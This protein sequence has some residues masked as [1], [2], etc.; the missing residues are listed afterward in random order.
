MKK[1]LIV[2]GGLLLKGGTENFI[3][4][5]LRSL[6]RKDYQVDVVVHGF[7]KGY[8]DDEI[9]SLGMQ[10]IHVPI[11]GQNPIKN[12]QALTEI[13]K[14]GNYDVIHAHLNDQNGPVLKMAKKYNIPV[15]ISHSH[16]SQ[17]YSSNPIKKILGQHARRLITPNS[18]SLFACSNSAGEYLYGKEDFE[19]I[20]NAIDTDHFLYDE[21]N[22]NKIR[23]QYDLEDKLVYGHIGWFN[24]IKN[25]TE[26]IKIFNELQKKQDNARLLL[27]G[28]GD[29]LESIKDQVDQLNLQD[30]VVFAGLQED[31]APF[32]SAMDAFIMPSLFEGL[33][34]VLVEAQTSGLPIY[35]SD[36]IDKDI[37][38]TDLVTFLPLNDRQK[39]VDT[40]L[41]QPLPQRQSR[42]KEMI[43]QG[44]DLKSSLNKIQEFYNRN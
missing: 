18:T 26:L 29:L 14:N 39:W 19:L 9:K 34:Y 41:N 1:I 33:P 15:R 8:Y 32:L 16:S 5:I 4:N 44:Y 22:R 23:K 42:Q 10:L 11:K 36:T 20:P 7:G 13:I 31:V 30:K 38:L 37:K 24:E 43:E 40:I 6:D 25:H 2:N 17:S 3:M 27:I 35:C 21:D 12:K 28:E